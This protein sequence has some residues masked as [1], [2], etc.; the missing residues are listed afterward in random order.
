MQKL[1]MIP[2]FKN[3]AAEQAF[4]EKHDSSEYLDWSKA[5][6]AVFPELKTSTEAISLRLPTSLLSRIKSAANKIDVP[7]QSFIKMIIDKAV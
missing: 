7:Y 6:L 4:W 3:E 2:Q 1:K 5:K